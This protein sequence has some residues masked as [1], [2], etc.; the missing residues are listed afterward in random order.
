MFTLSFSRLGRSIW[1][2]GRIILLILNFPGYVRLSRRLDQMSKPRILFVL[3]DNS[4]QSPSATGLSH[5]HLA[6]FF[7]LLK[8]MKIDFIIIRPLFGRRT[9]KT[10]SEYIFSGETLLLSRVGDVFL[11]KHNI[12][13]LTWDRILKRIQPSLVV[14]QNLSL[15]ILGACARQDILTA[16]IQ[17]GVWFEN[18]REVFGF[19]FNNV[20]G[21]PD[22]FLTW[23]HSFEKIVA[24]GHSKALT[25]GYPSPI[26]AIVTRNSASIDERQEA[27]LRVLITLSVGVV[28]SAD[29]FGLVRPSVDQILKE[30][31]NQSCSVVIRPHPLT[32]KNS[33]S[34]LIICRWLRREYPN[35]TVISSDEQ[36]INEA[37]ENADVIVTFDGTLVID[38]VLHGKVVLHASESNLLG[39]PEDILLS[40]LIGKYVSYPEM[41]KQLESKRILGNLQSWDYKEDVLS[42][43][44]RGCF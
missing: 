37:I 40:G 44:V 14:G 28:D 19:D 18:Q 2:R 10:K 22:Y 7:Q 41:K 8:D 25:I 27:Q 5:R 30:L 13:N 1:A 3:Y 34:K 31:A 6:K 43:F 29:P 24:N 36:D 39:V 35:A 20:G 38:A 23:H 26:T 15:P 16:E 11:N 17:H 32:G 4:F 21:T 42:Q 9:L 33:F 12:M